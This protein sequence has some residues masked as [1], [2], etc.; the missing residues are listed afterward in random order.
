VSQL[1]GDY[2]PY[3]ARLLGDPFVRQK[4]AQ[5]FELVLIDL[6]QVCGLQTVI[7]LDKVESMTASLDLSDPISIARLALPMTLTPALI[8][9]SLSVY[10]P[11]MQVAQILAP[12]VAQPPSHM[13][14][15]KFNDRYLM[16]D[17]YHRAYVFLRAGVR[18][19]PGFYKVARRYG[20]L[21]LPDG[22]LPPSLLARKRPPLLA[23]F[24]VDDVA[25]DIH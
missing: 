5:G 10:S 11:S 17:G 1:P 2:A 25:V 19:V 4:L 3:V 12:R 24:L 20:D 16:S 8:V 13:H 6:Y 14:V 7:S 18:Y 22:L 21:G 9:P 23:D 15:A